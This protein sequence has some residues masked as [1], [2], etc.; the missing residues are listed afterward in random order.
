[1]GTGLENIGDIPSIYKYHIPLYYIILCYII[2]YVILY[3][4]TLCYI[5]TYHIISYHIVL[6]YIIYLCVEFMDVDGVFVWFHGVSQGGP[7]QFTKKMEGSTSITTSYLKVN[8]R[9][10]IGFCHQ[11]ALG[12][13]E[14]CPRSNP[15]PAIQSQQNAH[16]WGTG[17]WRQLLSI[18]KSLFTTK[19][20]RNNQQKRTALSKLKTQ[21]IVRVHLTYTVCPNKNSHVLEHSSH[22]AFP[23]RDDTLMSLSTSH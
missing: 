10:L 18:E 15:H 19:K 16:L 12:R 17:H 7:T 6:Y 22:L 4:I 13:H 8:S 14:C 9:V 11:V 3:Y 5:K 20:P 21:K 1:M 23:G 2:Y